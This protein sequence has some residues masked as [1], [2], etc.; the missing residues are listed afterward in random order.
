MG[1]LCC[2]LHGCIGKW[3]TP[4]VAMRKYLL[5]FFALLTV[6][7]DKGEK[8]SVESWQSATDQKRYLYVGDLISRNL[9]LDQST[10]EIE[11]LLGAPS[12]KSDDYWTYVISTEPHGFN[13]I[14]VLQINFESGVATSAF[15]RS[16]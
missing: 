10:S 13:A 2:E 14:R 9:V 6:S 7:C 1:R 8:F 5:I 15:V 12:Y 16:D 3:T 11:L 4:D